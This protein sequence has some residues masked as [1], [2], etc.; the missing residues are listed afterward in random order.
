MHFPAEFDLAAACCRWPPSAARDAAVRAAAAG[1]DWGRFAEVAARHRI[2]GLA[3]D[4]LAAAAVPT[5]GP[6]AAA[7]A[8]AATQIARQNLAFAAEAG[9]LAA[10]LDDTGL[11]YLFVK[12]V[13]LNI[14]AYGSLALKR[15]ADIDIAVDRGAY[16]EAVR[17]LRRAGYACQAPGADADDARILRY[18][19]QTKH[20]LWTRNG[21]PVE[22]HGSLV[23]SPLMLKGVSVHSPQQRVAIA[24]GLA[25]PTL[26][27]D[28]LFAYLCVHGATHAWS[29]LKWLADVAALLK[30]DPPAEIERLHRR[31]IDLGGGR[32]SAQALLLCAQLLG[33]AL[34]GRL[35]RSLRGDRAHLFLVRS[36]LRSM[37]VGDGRA[38]LDEGVLS[39]AA[40]HVSHFRLMPGWRYKA[41]EL[42]RKLSPAA[43]TDGPAGPMRLLAPLLAGPQWLLRRAARARAGK[44]RG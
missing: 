34:P 18:A 12:G 39:T 9:R 42:R 3:H 33:T 37:L 31:A 43:G 17:V 44:G 32:S 8:L 23:D 10:A 30:H 25:L 20:T 24:P 41:A 22:L 11:P 6:V 28:E 7:L 5:P 29:R 14:L 2:E 36:A 16:G 13:T 26:A 38:E 1:V 19:G 27:K 40:I 21:I 15:A 35:E 4:A